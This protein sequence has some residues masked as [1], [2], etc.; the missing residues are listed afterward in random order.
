MSYIKI[1]GFH[2]HIQTMLP[3]SVNT[4]LPAVIQPNLSGYAAPNWNYG[5]RYDVTPGTPNSLPVPTASPYKPNWSFVDSDEISPSVTD[6]TAS[7]SKFNYVGAS[8]GAIHAIESLKAPIN[9]SYAPN[10]VKQVGTY[11]TDRLTNSVTIKRVVSQVRDLL[12]VAR[13]VECYGYLV[14]KPIYRTSLISLPSNRGY[15]DVYKIK[16]CDIDG[17]PSIT[18]RERIAARFANGIRFWHCALVNGVMTPLIVADG[19]PIGTLCKYDNFD[20]E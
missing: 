20:K 15:F 8:R 4:Q 16:D 18:V 14:N 19:Y 5:R 1:D 9:A 10:E 13:N 6:S 17:V 12:N 11:S 3:T 7:D 2:H